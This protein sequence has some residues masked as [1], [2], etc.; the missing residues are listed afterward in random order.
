MKD[1]VAEAL[2]W[3]VEDYLNAI[4]YSLDPDYVPVTLLWGS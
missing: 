3:K 2:P 4:D 1:P